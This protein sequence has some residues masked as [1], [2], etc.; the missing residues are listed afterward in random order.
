ME[1]CP[2]S[3]N[4]VTATGDK[5]PEWYQACRLFSGTQA[6]APRLMSRDDVQTSLT[7]SRNAPTI[8]AVVKRLRYL[9]N[10]SELRTSPQCSLRGNT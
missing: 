9:K 5:V 4:L 1:L 10:S 8:F 6:E 3:V 7:S 2:V